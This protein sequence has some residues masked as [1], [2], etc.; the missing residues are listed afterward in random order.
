LEAEELTSWASAIPGDG[1]E[2]GISESEQ[3]EQGEAGGPQYFPVSGV[4]EP[5]S[6]ARGCFGDPQHGQ[7]SGAQEEGIYMK[8]S[9]Q[10]PQGCREGLMCFFEGVGARGYRGCGFIF[11]VNEAGGRAQAENGLGSGGYGFFFR[12][13]EGRG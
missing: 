12:E 11:R 10:A 6:S 9:E 13:D 5:G 8:G 2:S 3:G 4:V 7:C 1:E